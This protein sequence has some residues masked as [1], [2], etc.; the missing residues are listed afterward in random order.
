MDI[1]NNKNLIDYINYVKSLPYDE[2]IVFLTTHHPEWITN[3]ILFD[4][5]NTAND[6]ILCDG[7]LLKLIES[8]RVGNIPRSGI[9]DLDT[10]EVGFL[11]KA[12]KSQQ[13][14]RFMCHIVFRYLNPING[15]VKTFTSNEKMECSICWREIKGFSPEVNSK[16]LALTA[17]GTQTNLCVSCYCQ[18]VMFGQLMETLDDRD[19]INLISKK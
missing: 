2:K 1:L 15:G 13:Y 12:W 16:D 19:F 14:H 8:H 11:M 17:S 5:Y 6:I 7:D 18:L 10:E 3:R 4:Y 9:E